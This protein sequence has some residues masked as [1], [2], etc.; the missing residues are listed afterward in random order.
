MNSERKRDEELSTL[1]SA[2][3]DGQMTTAE[4][5]RL[6]DLLRSNPG[7][8]EF[9]LD[10]C[11]THALLR[12][13]LGGR[14]DIA[15]LGDCTGKE[16]S[17]IFDR[18]RLRRGARRNWD[19]PPWPLPTLPPPPF[20]FL[21]SSFNLLPI[22]SRCFLRLAALCSPTRWQRDCRGRDVDRLGV[23]AIRSR[24]GR[25]ASRRPRL[26]LIP[27][28]RW[29]L[30]AASPARSIAGGR[31]PEPARSITPTS[32]WAADTPWLRDSWRSLTTPAP[33]SSSRGHARTR[34]SRKPAG[35]SVSAV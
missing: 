14:C 31:I 4:E 9:Y 16:G 18:P 32:P 3:L 6:G 5:S 17:P 19:I 15:S 29:S 35:I 33:R 22:E 10:Y 28:G 24:T 13:E 1:L 34:W 26:S 8:Q 11:A 20:P 27:I 30:S 23:Q 21:R 25:Q 12:Q 7:A 2:M